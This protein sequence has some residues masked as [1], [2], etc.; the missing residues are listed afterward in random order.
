TPLRLNGR[1]RALYRPR[2]TLGVEE[3]RPPNKPGDLLAA[4]RAPSTLETE[5]EVLRSRTVAEDVVDS[6]ALNVQIVEPRGTRRR[7]LFRMLRPGSDAVPGTYLVRGDA[8]RFRV[9]AR[10]GREAAGPDGAPVGGM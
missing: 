3:K 8:V 6:L 9:E 10:G 1:S 2:T 4:P 5:T 7:G